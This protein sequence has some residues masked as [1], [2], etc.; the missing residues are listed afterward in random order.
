MRIIEQQHEGLVKVENLSIGQAAKIHNPGRTG[1][2]KP[3]MRIG[4]GHSTVEAI[5]QL[6][7]GLI[8]MEPSFLLQPVEAE[9]IIKEYI[10]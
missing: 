10:A 3:V 1:H 9:V 5:V 8:W 2:G 6:D 4:L 7:D